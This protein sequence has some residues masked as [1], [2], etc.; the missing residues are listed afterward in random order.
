M[1]KIVIIGCARSGMEDATELI[2][3]LGYDFR[4]EDEQAE[5]GFS[6]WFH[7]VEKK[8][9]NELFFHQVKNPIK[10]IS[11]LNTISPKSW[12]FIKEHIKMDE[13]YSPLQMAMKYWIEWNKKAEKKSLFTFQSEQLP[14]AIKNMFEV[15]EFEEPKMFDINMA[16]YGRAKNQGVESASEFKEI[17]ADDLKNADEKLY[18]EVIKL[19]QKYGYGS[20]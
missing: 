4:N 14:T 5:N 13:N 7:V 1:S 20:L 10:V 12:E 16:F 17:N 18:K 2:K 6:S 15:A 8:K 9:E 19:S 3:S 11:T